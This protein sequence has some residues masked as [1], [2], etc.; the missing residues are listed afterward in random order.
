MKTVIDIQKHKNNQQIRDISDHNLRAT[1]SRNVDKN[2]TKNNK[3]F[4]GHPTIDP[5]EEMEKRLAK[6]PKFRKD[7]VK[8]VNLVLSASPEFFDSATKQEKQ[9][10]EK[11][12]QKWVEDTFGKDNIIYSVVH[13]DEKTP[14]FHIA[15]TPIKDGKLNAS[16]WFDGPKK[17]QKIHDDYSKAVKHLGIKRGIKGSVKPTQTETEAFYKKVNSSTAYDRQLDKKLEDLL[18]QIKSPT[19]TDRFNFPSF[20]EKTISPLL[21]QLKQNLSH[22]RTKYQESK[23]ALLE[24]DHLKKQVQD[25][26]VKLETLGI[27][28]KTPHIKLSELAPSIRNLV[29]QNQILS[30]KSSSSVSSET[31]PAPG[32]TPHLYKKP[33][34]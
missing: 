3:F 29:E 13:Y 33:K 12:T 4:V 15:F 19:L 11:T 10:W 30:K 34:I 28:P 5:I 9:D 25:L 27:D 18:E 22:Y 20:V 23:E 26:E 2:R 32:T 7:A 31:T 24:N 21:K 6:C 14:H 8:I 16:Y 1:S 17:L